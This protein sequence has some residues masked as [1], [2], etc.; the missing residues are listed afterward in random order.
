MLHSARLLSCCLG[1]V[2]LLV[3]DASL[4]HGQSIDLVVDQSQS[5][6]TA[7]A[8]GASDTSSITGTGVIDLSP[9][10]EPF[11][12][13]QVTD[14]DLSL[15][16]GFF[17]DTGLVDVIVEPDGAMVFFTE[18]GAAGMV[19]ANNQFD[20]TGNVFGI[21]GMALV[22]LLVGADQMVD[23]STVKPVVFNIVGAQLTVDGDMLTVE[24]AVDLDFEFEVFGMTAVMNLAGPVFLEGQLPAGI[25]GDINCDG[26]VNLLDVAPFVAQITDGTFS[27]KADINADGSVDLLDV[28]PF[29]ELLA[30]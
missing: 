18:V 2:L 1:L 15:A 3:V 30:G 16:D 28:A 24:A 7:T 21:S 6:A 25:V 4:L 23:L 29:V 17:I 26:E 14:L 20:Q 8:L 13:A 19:D 5:M 22:D 10:S 11:G 27:F 12:T 9:A